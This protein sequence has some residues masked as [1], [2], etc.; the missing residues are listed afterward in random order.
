MK[1]IQTSKPSQSGM[2]TDAGTG[3]RRG[4]SRWQTAFLLL[5]VGGV[6]FVLGFICGVQA[7]AWCRDL[8]AQIPGPIDFS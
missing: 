2:P 1:T 3:E 5:A 6:V 7:C 8:L 4:W